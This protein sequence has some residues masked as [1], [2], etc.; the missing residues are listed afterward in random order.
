[1]DLALLLSSSTDFHFP[2]MLSW[3]FNSEKNINEIK[4]NNSLFIVS[5]FWDLNIVN[6]ADLQNWIDRKQKSLHNLE[7][8]R[9]AVKF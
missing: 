4:R 5:V 9:I 6:E 1:M 2:K 3:A 8:F 7:A